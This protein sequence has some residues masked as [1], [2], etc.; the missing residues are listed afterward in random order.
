MQD[1]CR[2]Q[3]VF[4][5]NAYNAN[6]LVKVENFAM[7]SNVVL[8]QCIS[9]PLYCHPYVLTAILGLTATQLTIFKPS[10]ISYYLVTVAQV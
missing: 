9:H 1:C 4:R 2:I 6:S 3:I 8:I 10:V 7:L 5:D